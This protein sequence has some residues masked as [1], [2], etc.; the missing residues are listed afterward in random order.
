M[1][2]IKH[3]FLGTILILI[4]SKIAVNQ[5]EQVQFVFEKFNR[6]SLQQVHCQLDLVKIA[7]LCN[8]GTCQILEENAI[9]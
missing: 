9:F 2:T 6:I 4:A 3:D 1:H 5:K 8:T 7:L